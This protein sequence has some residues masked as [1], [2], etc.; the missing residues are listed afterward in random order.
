EE[1]VR[2]AEE[3]RVRKAEEERARMEAVR[4]AEEER[5]RKAEDERVRKAEDERARM[6]ADM[7][8]VRNVA[9]EV[10]NEI[11]AKLDGAIKE[12]IPAKIAELI[13]EEL[14]KRTADK[15]GR[16][17]LSRFTDSELYELVVEEILRGEP[18]ENNELKNAQDEMKKLDEP[19][20]PD[21]GGAEG[22]RS[23][24]ELEKEQAEKELT[25]LFEQK[26]SGQDLLNDES[27][28]DVF[29]KLMHNTIV[30]SGDESDG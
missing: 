30:S 20:N 2:K 29:K 11:E 5:V 21:L 10:S 17:E 15:I 18:N 3:E 23:S 22:G 24:E 19:T 13:D 9:K 12:A 1:R 27:I 6:K 14:V 26:E 8:F 25:K 16:E 7:E 4:H 28:V